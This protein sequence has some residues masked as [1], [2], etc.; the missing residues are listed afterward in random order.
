MRVCVKTSLLLYSPDLLLTASLYL[1]A[2]IDGGTHG[3]VTSGCHLLLTPHTCTR[4]HTP[5]SYSLVQTNNYILISIVEHKHVSSQL[6]RK[7]GWANKFLFHMVRK[8]KQVNKFSNSFLR[9][10]IINTLSCY[11]D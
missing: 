8:N 2:P 6:Q 5:D 4:V 1:H 7:M 10:G 11:C 3:S 9:P